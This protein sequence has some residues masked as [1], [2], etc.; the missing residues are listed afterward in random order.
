MID[1]LTP[2][3]RILVLM[4]QLIAIG[5][6]G[7]A[8]SVCVRAVSGQ[9]TAVGSTVLVACMLCQAF[10]HFR[11]KAWA[12]KVTAAIFAVAD[13]LAI[14]YLLAFFE[15]KL[16]PPLQIRI[17]TFIIITALAILMALNYRLYAVVCKA[18]VAG[19]KP[20]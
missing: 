9:T 3:Q 13:L 18:K 14:P 11:L 12:I 17:F 2:N 5:Y 8:V 15:S 4:N 6:V 16:L 20:E 7:L 1:R 10:G 19:A